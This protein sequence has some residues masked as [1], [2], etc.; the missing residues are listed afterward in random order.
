MTDAR[1]LERPLTKVAENAPTRALTRDNVTLNPQRPEYDRFRAW[2]TRPLLGRPAVLD[3][4]ETASL[5]ED[6]PALLRLLQELP[7]RLFDGDETAFARALGWDGELAT[8]ALELLSGPPMPVGRADLVKS[9]NGFQV[10]EFNTSSSLGS[11]EFGELCRAV[12]ADPAFAGAAG[13]LGLTYR[14][15][16]ALLADT[17]LK[18]TGRDPDD[19]PVVAL[20]GWLTEPFIVD[21]SL[22]TGLLQ[23]LGFTV[24]AG[25]LSDLEIRTDGVHLQGVR[26]DVVYRT[27]LLKTLA[28]GEH[29]ADALRPLAHAVARG[30]VFLFSPLNSDLFGSKACFAMLSDEENKHAFSPAELG[31]IDRLVPWTRSMT[32][33]DQRACDGTGSLAEHVMRERRELV[34]KP[35]IG[36]AGRGVVAGWMTEDDEWAQLVRTAVLGGYVV[37]RRVPSVAER[38]PLLDPTD[39]EHRSAGC[40][41]HWGLFVTDAGLSGGF[42]KGVLDRE[43]DIRYLGDGSHVGCI[44][45]A[46]VDETRRI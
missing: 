40:F 32:G 16:M 38:F 7:K 21:A 35:S 30:D 8:A 27:F 2:F 26:V 24:V 33:A 22:F 17:L 43:Q 44:F 29:S 20:V 10:V 11:F 46:P 37:Q 23:D 1:T 45:H 42:V 5:A 41:L 34:L 15:P 31:V 12:L 14:D 6:L 9:P 25:K 4:E 28:E 18:L 36:H 19:P 39:N 13:R 3:A